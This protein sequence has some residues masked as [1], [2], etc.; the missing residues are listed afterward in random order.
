MV[1]NKCIYYKLLNRPWCWLL[2]SQ[3]QR[4]CGLRS[5]SPWRWS[6]PQCWWRPQSEPPSPCSNA[7]PWGCRQSL[8]EDW[9][10]EFLEGK[11]EHQSEQCVNS[12]FLKKLKRIQQGRQVTH[13]EPTFRVVSIALWLPHLTDWW[14]SRRHLG[15]RECS[16]PGSRWPAPPWLAAQSAP[17][18][19]GGSGSVTEYGSASFR[20]NKWVELRAGN[21]TALKTSHL[22]PQHRH[23]QPDWWV[24]CGQTCFQRKE[25]AVVTHRHPGMVAGAAGNKDKSPT[26]LDLFD[27][28]LESTQ[29]HL[30]SHSNS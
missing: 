25:K 1:C 15:T 20:L 10:G 11:K 30:K 18:A 13:K 21:V 24:Q 4:W 23:F 2:R 6:C 8:L 29:G 9:Q 16:C 26:P 3:A 19:P 12:V 17:P 28:V 5:R 27:V 14:R 7:G 22:C